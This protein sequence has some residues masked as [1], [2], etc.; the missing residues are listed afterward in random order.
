MCVVVRGGLDVDRAWLS[1]FG[2]YGL[3]LGTGLAFE[4]G[5][6]VQA[7]LVA[8][9]CKQVRDVPGGEYC[10]PKIEQVRRREGRPLFPVVDHP[11]KTGDAVGAHPQAQFTPAQRRAARRGGCGL[12]C[13]REVAWW[14][15]H[16]LEV[17]SVLQKAKK[18]PAADN[19]GFL[20]NHAADTGTSRP[21]GQ[22]VS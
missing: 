5:G 11:P 22:R 19:R 3:Q 10:D 16:I 9:S 8:S 14:R 1:A 7:E 13:G 21:C 15:C 2:Q 6:D 4:Q 20:E 18:S 12:P 17:R